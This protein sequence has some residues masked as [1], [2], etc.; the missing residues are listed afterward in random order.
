MHDATTVRSSMKA[1]F[2]MTKQRCYN[3]KCRDYPYYGGRG[4]RICPEWL[5]SFDVFVEDMGLRPQGMTL[6][7]VDVNGDYCKENCLWASRADQTRNRRDTLTITYDGRTASLTEWATETGI[8]YG[9]LKARVQR[10]GYTSEQALSKTVKAGKK[11]LGKT[12][13]PRR[14]PDMSK[15]PKGL[16]HAFT[17]FD[18]QQVRDLR[19]EHSRGSSFS[20]LARK[21]GVSVET[22]SNAVQGLKAYKETL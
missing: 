15:V 10:L 1:A 13:P 4:I 22:V 8:P 16:S 19:A 17:V 11:V 6:E 9:T 21:Y 20:A 7:R 14:T 5:E 3:P 2:H 18:L 12:Y